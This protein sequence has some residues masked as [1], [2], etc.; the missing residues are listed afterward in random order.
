[1]VE[2]LIQISLFASQESEVLSM[3]SKSKSGKKYPPSMYFLIKDGGYFC[4]DWIFFPDFYF[5]L[6][7]KTSGSCVCIELQV[8]YNIGSAT[9]LDFLGIMIIKRLRL[10]GSNR[11]CDDMSVYLSIHGCHCL[12]VKISRICLIYIFESLSAHYLKKK[13]PLRK[14]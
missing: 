11:H 13:Q 2:H 5:D 9:S 8:N 14:Q 7:D 4:S 1:M 12:S 6:I 10:F 3:T